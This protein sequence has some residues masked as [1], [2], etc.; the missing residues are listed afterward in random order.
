M[1]FTYSLL[2]TRLCSLAS[3]VSQVD[4]FSC[5]GVRLRFMTGNWA[6]ISNFHADK[7]KSRGSPLRS[8]LSHAKNHSSFLPHFFRMMGTTTAEWM[9]AHSLQDHPI[10]LGMGVGC[11]RWSCGRWGQRL[12]S[13][14]KHSYIEVEV[15]LLQTI[16]NPKLYFYLLAYLY[17]N[18][19]TATGCYF[20][21]S[22]RSSSSYRF[23]DAMC[24]LAQQ[25]LH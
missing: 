10:L 14:D 24:H 3:L 4:I 12:I 15:L 9:T 25:N 21:S 5:F 11:R 6:R 22:P 13:L 1:S 17:R 23:I 18:R 19:T 8:I 16:R 20:G 7:W 2:E